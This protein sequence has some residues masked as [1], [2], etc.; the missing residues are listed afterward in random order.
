MSTHVCAGACDVCM[1]TT[2]ML[3]SSSV[4][5]YLM[6][7]AV[8]CWT[9]NSPSPLS[10]LEYPYFYFQLLGFQAAATSTCFFFL[11]GCW[12]FELWTSHLCSKCFIH[13]PTPHIPVHKRT[14]PWL[15]LPH[16]PLLLELTTFLLQHIVCCNDR[17]M[18]PCLTCF[19][20]LYLII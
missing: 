3:V 2:L 20:N 15:L 16:L 18:Q 17:Y 10:S 14:F 5:L 12:V 19:S 7:E 4:S 11:C 13:W 8:C 1:V 6:V 9:W